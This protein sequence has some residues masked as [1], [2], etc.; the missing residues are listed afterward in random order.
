VTQ[1]RLATFFICSLMALSLASLPWL[2]P[3]WP[4]LAV[5]LI[6]GAGALGVFPI[7]H[8]FTQ[9]LSH[10]HQGKVTGIAGVAAWAFSP[11]AQ[12]LFGQHVDATQSFDQG[13]AAAGCLPMIAML[14][15]VLFWPRAEDT[16]SSGPVTPDS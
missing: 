14:V 13:L 10:R 16:H 5:L 4:L 1:A 3:G 2:P 11:L 15:L 12:R 7:Y 9:D 6:A 8:A